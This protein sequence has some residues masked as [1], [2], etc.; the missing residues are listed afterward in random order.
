MKDPLAIEEIFDPKYTYSFDKFRM[1]C[2]DVF[3][4]ALSY[5]RTSDLMST[6][7]A[8]F[9][10]SYNMCDYKVDELI[11]VY[12]AL[13]SYYASRKLSFNFNFMNYR[14]YIDSIR[15]PNYMPGMTNSKGISRSPAGFI[16]YEINRMYTG[17]IIHKPLEECKEIKPKIFRPNCEKYLKHALK[18]LYAFKYDLNRILTF[19]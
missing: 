9:D 12:F 11:K 2:I 5:P 16:F 13:N 15:V 18:T 7:D 8:V 1:D 17:M 3:L 6:I 4:R 14:N 10:F 19:Y